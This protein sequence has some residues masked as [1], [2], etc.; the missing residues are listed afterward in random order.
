MCVCVCVRMGSA[1]QDYK[2]QAQQME[3]RTG[4]MSVSTRVITDS[5]HLDMY[6]QVGP[7][8]AD[9]G[10]VHAGKC[11]LPLRKCRK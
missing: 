7:S 3:R 10:L 1:T 6:E 5:T 9:L 8:L 4:G 2:Q 11:P